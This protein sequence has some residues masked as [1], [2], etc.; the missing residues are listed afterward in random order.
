[1][2]EVGTGSGYV[3]AV[4]GRLGREVFSIER[5]R[6]LALSA[7]ERVGSLGLAHVRIATGDGLAIARQFGMFDR[8]LLNGTVEALPAGLITALAPGG[9]L[10]AARRSDGH[11]R[12]LR[13]ESGADGT[14]AEQ[15]GAT[16]RLPPLV[17]GAAAAL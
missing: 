2:L 6:T 13:V 5:F 10:V 12:L 15:H 7:A 8:I 11:A 3:S 1:V 14:L 17:A 4:L 9:R 16:L